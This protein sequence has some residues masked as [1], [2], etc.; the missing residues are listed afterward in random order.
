MKIYSLIN[1]NSDGKEILIISLNKNSIID[2]IK[3]Q[4]E[5][6]SY[7]DKGLYVGELELEKSNIYNIDDFKLL[8]KDYIELISKYPYRRWAHFNFNYDGTE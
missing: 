1:C 6:L 7:S 5:D 3:K 2:L 8:S 4:K